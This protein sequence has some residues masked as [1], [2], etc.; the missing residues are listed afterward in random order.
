[1]A[2]LEQDV[3]M[4]KS[5]SAWPGFRVAENS[6]EK[7]K[8]GPKEQIDDTELF[9]MRD[10]LI[11]WLEP[12]W[13]WMGDRLYAASNPGEIKVILEAAARAL[14]DR[15]DW[16]T[17]LLDNTAVLFEFLSH[18]RFGKTIAKATVTDALTLPW[19][20]ERRRRAA[21]QLPARKV[22]NALAGVPEIGWRRSLDRCSERPS[23]MELAVNLDLHYREQFRIPLDPERDLTGT[24]S[25]LP[26]RLCQASIDPN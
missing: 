2:R 6:P 19:E 26:K 10:G 24:S 21:N 23:C 17:R 20:T 22:A 8:P 11:M 14:E 4:L 5:L 16:Q 13:P 25:P 9:R 7:Q 1:M 15:Q 12:Y 3:E 18:E